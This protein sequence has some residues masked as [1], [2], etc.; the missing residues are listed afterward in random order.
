MH[1]Y[2][3]CIPVNPAFAVP[4]CCIPHAM[5]EAT[6]PQTT[7]EQPRGFAPFAASRENERAMI[8]ARGCAE[9]YTRLSRSLLVCV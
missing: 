9:S 7:D 3:R 5:E 1:L 6:Q 2:S 8:Q 4:L